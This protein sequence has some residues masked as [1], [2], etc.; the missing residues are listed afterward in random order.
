M[1][2]ANPVKIGDQAVALLRHCQTVPG[3]SFGGPSR[4]SGTAFST[5]HDGVLLYLVQTS[6]RRF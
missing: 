1:I 5:W 3:S 2:L 4:P 6:T